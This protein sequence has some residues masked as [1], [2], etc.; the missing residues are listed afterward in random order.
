MRIA[1][2]DIELRLKPIKNIILRVH[3]D[4]RL[5][6]SAPLA[7]REETIV[8]FVE[9]RK[10]WIERSLAR[11]SDLRERHPEPEWSPSEALHAHRELKAYIADRLAY[12]A[13]LMGVSYRGFCIKSMASKW[14]S[15]HV[16]SGVLTFNLRLAHY[17]LRCCEYVVVHELAHLLVPNHSAAFYALLDRYYPD[18]KEC[19]QALK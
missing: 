11:I 4:G 1:D 9:S 17:P 13:P 3:R 7:T 12:W 2:Y 19:R 14:G 18:W 6:L 16:R 8:R 5:S 10:D 15:C